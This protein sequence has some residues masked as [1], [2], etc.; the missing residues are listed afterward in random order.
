MTIYCACGQ[1]LHY[2]DPR[3]QAIV[4]QQCETLGQDIRVRIGTRIFLM[5]RH[6]L[7]LH[8]VVAADVPNLKF[9]ELL[10]DGVF[11]PYLYDK[12][13]AR[14]NMC[15]PDYKEQ[16]FTH[17]D[18]DDQFRHFH[19]A[20]LVKM[21]ERNPNAFDIGVFP[22]DPQLVEFVR[23]NQGTD[24]G[25]LTRMSS[26]FIDVPGIICLFADG[27]QLIVDGN[28]R[29]VKR[30]ELGRDNMQFHLIPESAWRKSL[31]R[32]P[33]SFNKILNKG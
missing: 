10:E 6:Y 26:Q 32:V 5:P 25:Y 14:I 23:N 11:L 20:K 31:L 27:S 24:E 7:A 17:H 33:E 1:P 15:Q 4:Q 8:N 29:F 28:H 12:G 16:Y 9:P 13:G 21:I 22:I 19:I 30:Y 3:T 18:L 2:D